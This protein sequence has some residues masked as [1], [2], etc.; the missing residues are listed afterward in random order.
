VDQSQSR[1][2]KHSADVPLRPGLIGCWP[3]SRRLG[4]MPCSI[5]RRWQLA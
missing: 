3:A 5:R 4:A 1:L 2:V